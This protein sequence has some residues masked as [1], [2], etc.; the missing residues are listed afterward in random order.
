MGL[1]YVQRNNSKK[2]ILLGFASILVLSFFMSLSMLYQFKIMRDKV[3]SQFDLNH[4]KS[5]LVYTMRDAIR[6]RAI[7]LR[8]MANMED[9]FE[10]D[11]EL[12]RFNENA[13]RYAEARHILNEMDI[14]FEEKQLHKEL[15]EAVTKSQPL[16]T[17]AAEILLSEEFSLEYV[18]KVLNHAFNSQEAV[19]GILDKLVAMQQSQFHETLDEFDEN[20]DSAINLLIVTG[21]FVTLIVILIMQ[22]LSRYINE[23]NT[24]L[25]EAAETKSMFLANM[26]HEIRTPLTAI[27]GFTDI[28]NRKNL[29]PTEQKPVIST[30]KKNAKHLLQLIND[31]LDI[32]KIEANK[33]DIDKSELNL[34][35]FMQDIKDLTATLAEKKGLEFKV[36]YKYPLPQLISS[37]QVRLKQILVNLCSNASKFTENGHVYINIHYKR[38]SNK[39]Y[40]EIEDTGIGLTQEQ[41]DNIFSAFTQ[42]DSSTTRKYGGTGLGLS[43]CKQLVEKLGGVITVES[44]VDKGSVFKF[45]IDPGQVDE[46]DLCLNQ[47]EMETD[48]Q[49]NSSEYVEYETKGTVLLVEDTIDNQVLISTY[50]EDMGAEVFIANNGKEAIELAYKNTFDLILMDMQM[51]VMGGVDAVIALRNNNYTNPIAMLTAN[52]F[53]KE[54]KQCKK[55]GCDAFLVKPINLRELQ[56]LVYTY[57]GANNMELTQSKKS[58]NVTEIRTSKGSSEIMSSMMNKN[59]KYDRLIHKYIAHLPHVLDNI[60]QA[61]KKKDMDTLGKL[62][63]Q[64]KGTGGNYGYLELTKLSSSIEQHILKNEYRQIEAQLIQLEELLK[65]INNGFNRYVKNKKSHG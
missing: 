22:F 10:R 20:Y 11:E 5:E 8:N 7:N 21:I 32:S 51:P 30:I 60:I 59:D 2:L 42:A 4:Q 6:L 41:M 45:S 17:Q 18:K 58:N 39:L 48:Y 38:M 36:Q 24:A 31:I 46:N 12:L 57:L 26:S 15:H 27:I 37:D 50:L 3:N 54:R 35:E 9:I 13:G 34:F 23:T 40:F 49:E 47:S 33:L 53:E 25:A 56:K 55:I 28:L 65:K 52:A 29:N 14:S 62:I 19:L 43:I 64:L 16:N 61:Y 44:I 63:H 1:I